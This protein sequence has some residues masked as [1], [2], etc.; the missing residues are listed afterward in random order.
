MKEKA[1]MISKAMIIITMVILLLPDALFA[2]PRAQKV[3]LMCGSQ[4]EHNTTLF[5]PNFVATMENI[6]TQMRVSGFGLAEV[7]S[8]P[9]K[10]Y[11]LA[12]CYGDL[13]LVD[14]VLCYAE[15][16]TV[17]PQCYPVNGGRI[18][19]DGCFMRAENYSFY[20]EYAS[21]ID[22][23]ECGNITQPDSAFKL[24]VTQAVSQAVSAAES[25]YGYG[26]AQVSVAG[27]RNESAYVLANCWRTINASGC[28]ACLENAS[29]SISGCLPSSEGRALNTGCFMRYSDT[30]FL[31]PVPRNG[32][33]RGNRL[34]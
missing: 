5:V 11:G 21:P 30:N 18:Y 32:S 14:C 33:S 19:L 25:N 6:S 4:L 27:R 7:G 20:E 26:R 28:R 29:A 3:K 13:S 17:L 34:R 23:V 24:S 12:Q 22:H 15:A 2:E 10:N 8:G 1:I 9:D 16:R 31:N